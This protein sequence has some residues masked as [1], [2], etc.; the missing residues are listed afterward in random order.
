MTKFTQQ[1][2]NASEN[3][4]TAVSTFAKLANQSLENA[5][6]ITALQYEVASDFIEKSANATKDLFDAKTPAQ[7]TNV[8]K[9]FATFSVESTLE[10]S[11]E[12]LNVIAKSQGAFKDV[13]NTS[14]KNAS[15]LILGSI[16]Q[17]AKVNPSWSKAAS[18][19]VQKVIDAT[20]KAQ[21]TFEK[22]ADQVSIITNKNVEAAANTALNTIKKTNANG[23]AARK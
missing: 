21:E 1:F 10:K 9:D 19:S 15:D 6:K 16:D 14:F 4:S 17:V 20:S 3:Y 2:T 12:I 13:A 8:I 5:Q 22:V 18:E 11:R 7:A 23:F